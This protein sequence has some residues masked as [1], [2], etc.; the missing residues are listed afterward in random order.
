[1]KFQIS[2]FLIYQKNL[3]DHLKKMVSD[4]IISLK[5][6]STGQDEVLYLGKIRP[7][8]DEFLLFQPDFTEADGTV[9]G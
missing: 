4:L 3:I 6:T 1:M 2:F 8:T 5:L 7:F 9:L